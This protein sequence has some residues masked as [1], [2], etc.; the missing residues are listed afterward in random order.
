VASPDPCGTTTTPLQI[1][2]GWGNPSGPG[3][4]SSATIATIWVRWFWFFK[5]PTKAVLFGAPDPNSNGGDGRI[6]A[7]DAA[8]GQ[9]IWK[10][11]VIAPTS[12]TSK[13]GY[14]SPA[15]AHGRAYIGVSAKRPD[16]PITVGQVFAVDLATG[17]R[18][19]GFGFSAVGGPAPGGGIWSSPA[20]APDG[21]VVVT[22]GNSCVN[23]G[24]IDPT[25]CN[26][27]HIPSPDYTNSILKVDW[28]TGKTV[29]WQVQPV[30]IQYDVDPDF[31]ASALVGQVS[32]GNR[33]ISVQKDGYVH[34]VDINA[35][36]N[37]GCSYP[38][39]G[40]ACPQW[41]FPTATL[42]FQD[43][44][45]GDT[46][47]KRPGALDR[48]HLFIAAGGFNL[49]PPPNKPITQVYARLHC[50]NVCGSD[51]A[52]IRWVLPNLVGNAGG[53]SVANGVIY[54]GTWT[55]FETSPGGLHHFYAIADTDYLPP[56]RPVPTYVCSYDGLSIL[57]APGQPS[58]CSAANFDSVPVPV[59]VK[60]TTL[61]GSIQAIPAISK[62]RVYVA[63]AAGHLYALG[64]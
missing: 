53:V 18:D 14:S 51:L 23:E 56:L 48:D 42:P 25:Y 54:L 37:S 15:L 40:L 28:R 24:F 59:I 1:A 43:Y 9:C 30:A 38:G 17:A 34:A 7:L 41:T 47:F 62:G 44:N 58:P 63:T 21:N 57:H 6:W 27:N 5:W 12:G 20:I 26:T 8:T 13:I 52:R 60:D 50:L 36:T 2:A 22:T 45:H 19:P 64:L 39:H 10:S 4:A 31:S 11:D 16:D 3:I 46:H 55:P 33:A 35:T 32:C 29:F 49:E 61:V